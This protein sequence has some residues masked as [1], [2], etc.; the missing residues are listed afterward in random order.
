MSQDL[1]LLPQ[2]TEQESMS[3]GPADNHLTIV[4]YQGW[5][6]Y[7]NG[8]ELPIKSAAHHH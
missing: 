1:F 4:L 2:E 6:N 5:T 7:L 3:Y 8:Y